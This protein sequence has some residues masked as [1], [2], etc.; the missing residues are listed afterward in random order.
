MTPQ[1]RAILEGLLD[2]RQ[3]PCGLIRR[4]IRAALD[5]IDRMDPPMPID[6]YPTEE[7]RKLAH[8]LQAALMHPKSTQQENPA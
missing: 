6:H 8:E 1:D 4:A 5:E 7:R 2:G 3:T